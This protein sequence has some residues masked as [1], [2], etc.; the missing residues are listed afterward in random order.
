MGID[1]NLH[2]QTRQDNITQKKTIL[3]LNKYIQILIGLVQQDKKQQNKN[4]YIKHT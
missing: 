3:F 1:S 4:D 2:G